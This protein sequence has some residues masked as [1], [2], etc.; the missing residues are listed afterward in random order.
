MPAPNNTNTAA[1]M[2]TA[3]LRPREIDFVTQFNKNWDALRIAL[4]I[5]RPI[6]KQP[7][8]TLQSVRAKVTLAQSVGEG[9]TINNSGVAYEVVKSK[10]LTVEKYK[11][12]VTVEAVDRYGA[13]L[14]VEK[15]D[16]A[17]M[18]ELQAKVMGSFYA[19]LQTG[20]LTSI[21]GSFQMAVAMAIGRVSDKFK[22]MHRGIGDI[23]VFVNTLDAHR[24]IGAAPITIQTL[25]G[26][27][28]VENFVGARVMVLSSDIPQGVVIAIP[29]GNIDLYYVDPGDSNFAKLGLNYVTQGET[30][31]IGFHA[32]GNYANATG[33]VYALMGMTLWAEYIDGIAVV[34]IDTNNSIPRLASLSLGSLTLSPAFDPDITTYTARTSNTTNTITA[35]GGE[36]DTVVIKNGSTTV[37]SGNSATW[38][39]GENVVTVTT[40]NE[41]G[42]VGTYKVYVTKE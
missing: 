3:G 35:T 25:N 7:G 5:S 29:Q 17:F 1:A 8:T 20:Q 21:E 2:A 26:I 33:D 22:K 39:D 18:D 40:T 13:E 4:G 36:D 14:A 23:A 41:A 32:E 30:N 42:A 38:V 24:Y 15:T 10:N 31:L 37:T 16:E 28:Y 34:I 6:R 11:T 19:F 12:S 9:E 27:Q